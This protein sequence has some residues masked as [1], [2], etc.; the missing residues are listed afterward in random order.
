MAVT[1]MVDIGYLFDTARHYAPVSKL[2]QV[3]DVLAAI[4]MNV[5]HWHITDAEVRLSCLVA[6][7][8]MKRLMQFRL[9][10]S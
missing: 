5:F 8:I 6:S 1:L 10:I 9:F 7:S 3:I 2:K 4:K